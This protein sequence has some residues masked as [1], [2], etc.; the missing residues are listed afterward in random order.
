MPKRGGRWRVEA[1]RVS[2]HGLSLVALWGSISFRQPH[3]K[4]CCFG[5]VF[6]GT[7]SM[8]IFVWFIDNRAIAAGAT[9]L[10]NIHP[11]FGPKNC[12]KT[13][14][15]SLFTICILIVAPSDGSCLRCHWERCDKVEEWVSID[16]QLFFGLHLHVV[17]LLLLRQVWAKYSKLLSSP[18]LYFLCRFSSLS[19]YGSISGR[20]D[21]GKGQEAFMKVY[22]AEMQNGPFSLEMKKKYHSLAG[23]RTKE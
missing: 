16:W 18:R 8:P 7:R 12:W 14:S 11:H 21:D 4:A 1:E 9:R 20:M 2:L 15:N 10:L 6:S 23:N 3:W 17:I 22:I 5:R 19:K 13:Q